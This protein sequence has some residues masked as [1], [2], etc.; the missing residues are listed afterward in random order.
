MEIK[1]SR[2][3]VAADSQYRALEVFVEVCLIQPVA[4]DLGDIVHR[5]DLLLPVDGNVAAVAH[6]RL[7]VRIVLDLEF[8]ETD[9]ERKFG[10]AAFVEFETG[11]SFTFTQM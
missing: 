1:S 7:G 5:D 2:Y 6:G 8:V 3:A 9:A 11:S 4:L 10:G